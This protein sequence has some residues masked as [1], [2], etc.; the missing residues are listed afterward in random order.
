MAAPGPEPN[1]TLTAEQSAVEGGPDKAYAG[2]KRRFRPEADVT[3]PTSLTDIRPAPRLD[4]ATFAGTG[5][6]RVLL[7]RHLS[8]SQR[9]AKS[10]R[11]SVFL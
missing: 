1:R 3:D 2:H 8:A 7:R 6:R 4:T 9:L 11:Q 5:N 10:F